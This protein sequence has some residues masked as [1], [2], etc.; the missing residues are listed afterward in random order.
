[1]EFAGHF[2]GMIFMVLMKDGGMTLEKK[3]QKSVIEYARSQGFIAL[4]INVGSQRGWPDY[5]LIDPQGWHVWI[6]FKKLGQKPSPLQD[7]RA[8][9]L[10]SRN[11]LVVVVDTQEGGYEIV[12]SLVAARVSKESD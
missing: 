8:E 4:K 11:V 3:T 2:K 6:E 7:F 10:R 9:E 1:M 5:I 12:D